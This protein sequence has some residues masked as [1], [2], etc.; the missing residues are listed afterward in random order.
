MKYTVIPAL[1]QIILRTV[2]GFRYSGS[3]D[4]SPLS[5]PLYFLRLTLARPERSP[6]AIP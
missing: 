2:H 5:F 4:Y 3:M 1:M 6:G